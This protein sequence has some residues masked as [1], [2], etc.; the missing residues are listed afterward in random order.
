MSENKL[1]VIVIVIV[2][3]V[4]VVWKRA[5]NIVSVLCSVPFHVK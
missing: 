1:F 2:V 3:I 5:S 4:N